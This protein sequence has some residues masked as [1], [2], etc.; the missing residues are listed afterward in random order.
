MNDRKATDGALHRGQANRF[1]RLL[2]GHLQAYLVARETMRRL[3][4]SPGP[5]FARDWRPKENGINGS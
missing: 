5:C 4:Q 3:K 1:H 2:C